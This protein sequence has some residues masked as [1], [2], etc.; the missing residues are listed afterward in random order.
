MLHLLKC[1]VDMDSDTLLYM[2][3]V[4]QCVGIGVNHKLAYN[5]LTVT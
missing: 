3:N 2:S 5:I 1:I 4:L